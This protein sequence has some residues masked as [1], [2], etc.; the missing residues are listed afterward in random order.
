MLLMVAMLAAA[1]GA[2]AV[3]RLTPSYT[4]TARIR[5]DPSRS[6]LAGNPQA[7]RTELTPEAIETEVSGIRSLELATGIARSFGLFADPEF[8]GSLDPA[9]TRSLAVPASVLSH[10][11]VDREALAFVLSVRFTSADPVKAATL[12]NAFADGYIDRRTNGKL[13][14]AARQSAW[15]Q[16][17][18]EELGG[19]AAAAE[20][21]AAEFRAAAGILES[22]SGGGLGTINDQQVAPL[23]SSL[24]GA[25]SDAAAARSNLAAARIQVAHGGLDAVSEV[26]GSAVIADLRR[27][28]AETLRSRGEVDARYGERHPESIRVRDQLASLDSQL[29][30]ES[31]RVVG[32]LQATAAAADARAG[33]LRSA[34]GRLESERARSTRDSVAAA[35]LERE[36][37]AKRALYDRMSQLSLDSMQNARLSMAQAEVIERAEPPLRPSAPDKPLLYALALFG[38]LVAGS[39]TILALDMISGGFASVE[40]VQRRLGLPVLAIVPSV[41]RGLNPLDLM[42]ERPTVMFAESFRVAWAAL[43]N[44]GSGAGSRAS[45][46]DGT[47]TNSDV[48]PQVLALASSLPAEGKSTSAIALARTMAL[49]GAR[50]LLVDCATRRASVRQMVRARTPGAGLVEVL[51]D[52]VRLDDAIQPG[53]VAGLDHLLVA[54]PSTAAGDLFGNGRMEQLLAVLRGRYDHVVLDLP[55]LMGLADGRFLAAL[56]DATLL[57]VKWNSTPVPAALSAVEWLRRDGSNPIG[58][59]FTQVDPTARAA[60]GMHHYAKRYASYYPAD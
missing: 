6:P 37:A 13:G 47:A 23:A 14:T 28:R 50:T 56:A 18:L 34:L 1:I 54:R 36:A 25:E 5:L 30:A 60:G 29:E 33:S 51:R 48:A 12:A 44:A 20:A 39:V 32:A 7:Q 21:R 8:T 15:F 4:S 22:R 45:S 41:A 9:A 24:A 27:Q 17:R 11:T 52:K 49:S 2:M 53:D 35:A 16:Q 38:G 42:L 31:R 59:L 3:A 58:I 19:E 55:P 10:L 43:G 57:V 46:D 26:L 40:Q